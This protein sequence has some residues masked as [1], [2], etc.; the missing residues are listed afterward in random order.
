VDLLSC[1]PF[2]A[3]NFEVSCRFLE[4]IVDLC[5]TEVRFVTREA[6]SNVRTK[7][8]SKSTNADQFSAQYGHLYTLG[9]VPAFWK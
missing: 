5:L 3:S 9:I 6:D 7:S 2:G 8:V 1:H 4:K